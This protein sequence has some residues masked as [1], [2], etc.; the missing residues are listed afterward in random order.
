[1]TSLPL[2]LLHEQPSDEAAIDYLQERA[3]GPGRFA[4]SAY[5]LR[6]GV[7][8]ARDL[9][10]VARVGT[11][12]VGSNRMTPILI[13]GRE[14]LLLGPLVVDPAFRS[15]GIGLALLN[16]SLE[17]AATNGHRLVMLVGDEPYYA[18]VGFTRVPAGRVSLPGPVDPRRVL[19]RALVEGA[20]DGVAGEARRAA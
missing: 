5:R 17:A 12:L 19:W 9:S 7:A 16:A 10:F 15:K 11:F 1:M 13:G 14:A 8:P 18:R 4:R 3:F 20:E 6:E 2:A